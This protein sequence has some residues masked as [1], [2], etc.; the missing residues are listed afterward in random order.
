MVGGQHS[1]VLRLGLCLFES[2]CLWLCK[3]QVLLS[4]FSPPL[5]GTGWL[6]SEVSHPGS[7]RLRLPSFPEGRPWK[8]EHC[9][10]ASSKMVPFPLALPETRGDLAPLF[11]VG[12]W[13]RPWREIPQCSVGGSPTTRTPWSFYLSDSSTLSLRRRFFSPSSCLPPQ[14][15][16][17]LARFPLLRLRCGSRGSSYA[18]GSRIV[19]PAVCSVSSALLQLQEESLLFQSVSFVMLLGWSGDSQAPY[20]WNRTARQF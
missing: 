11:S 17:V 8:E 15:A 1:A 12:I 4:F 2:L 19:G 3:S 10:L 13:S 18:R 14:T 6:E 16:L 9:A 7:V 5:G 20:V